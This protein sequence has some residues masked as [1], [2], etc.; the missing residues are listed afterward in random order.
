MRRL[1]QSV[2]CWLIV[3][4]SVCAEVVLDAAPKQVDATSTEKVR[5]I[6]PAKNWYAGGA[7]GFSQL[8]GW[9]DASNASDAYY[10]TYGYGTYS[11]MP[12]GWIQ[13][14]INDF[15]AKVAFE[16]TI[17]GGYRPLNFLDIELGY[18][19][20]YRWS[21]TN[22]YKNYSTGDTIK[23]RRQIKF[24]AL[25]VSTSIR[26]FPEGRGHGLYFKLGGH[27]SELNVSKDI[28]G[29]PSNLGTIAAGDNLPIDGTS[30]GYGSLYGIGFDFKTAKT[31]AVRL[32][33]SH[34][35]KLGGTDY[36]KSSLNIGYQ[37]NF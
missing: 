7:V 27:A 5:V 6:S 22:D 16:G 24:Q 9:D 4:N 36:G 25:Y 20:D 31:G 13:A 23:S 12:H 19:G 10:K 8:T 34:Y 17:Y 37:G 33:W 28:T 3:S 2:F 26:P 11:D 15:F 1:L 14:I 32:E 21:S 18:T 35:N 30:R 29:T